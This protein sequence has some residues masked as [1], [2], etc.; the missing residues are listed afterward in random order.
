MVYKWK[1]SEPKGVNS[2]NSWD[3]KTVSTK[4]LSNERI[5][6]KSN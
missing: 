3:E 6:N 5:N 1:M 4:S 2:N